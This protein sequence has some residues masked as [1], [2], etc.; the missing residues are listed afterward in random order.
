MKRRVNR[1]E[2]HNMSDA[3]HQFTNTHTHI[4]LIQNTQI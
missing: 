3:V 2:T 1:Y 4:P